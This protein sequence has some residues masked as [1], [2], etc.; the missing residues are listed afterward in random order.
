MGELT[1]QTPAPGPPADPQ[2]FNRYAYT[3]NNPL[4]FIDPTGKYFVVAAEMRQ[5]VQQYISTMLRSPQGAATIN[6]IAASNRPVTFGLGS[7]GRTQHGNSIS[8]TNGTTVPVAGSHP[9][10][11]GGADV[12]LDN[13]NISFTA[14]HT[15]GATDFSMGLKAFAHEDQHVTDILGASTFQ[16]AA[17]AGAAGDA[18]SAP[19]ANDT[20][21]GSAEGR[22]LDIMG[23]L[24]AAGQNYQPDAQMDSLAAGILD[25]GAA[26]QSGNAQQLIQQATAPSGCT[27]SSEGGQVCH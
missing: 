11:V 9:G 17:A 21:G 20:T 18:P 1:F 16:G 10:E 5:Q 8:V 7:L 3:R 13:N 6:A 12:K 25:Q 4:K 22:A 2:T 26:I 24:G 19:G 15:N 23:E 27:S 14:A